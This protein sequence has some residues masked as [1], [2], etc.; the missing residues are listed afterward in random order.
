MSCSNWVKNYYR[1]T[2]FSQKRLF[3]EFLLSGGQTV[4]LGSN[5]RAFQW[6]SVKELSN[7]RLRR[8][9]S[10][11]VPELCASLS[12]NGWNRL[13]LTFGDLWWP[14]LWPDL[15][16][17]RS[18]FVMIFDA[19]REKSRNLGDKSRWKIARPSWARINKSCRPFDI[20]ANAMVFYSWFSISEG[21]V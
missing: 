8:T 1:K 21:G 5:L 6:K 12:K 20:L 17:D 18:N 13:N 14:D 9:L 19:F 2:F 3:L 11:L 16:N 15:K 10:L 7:A 4:E